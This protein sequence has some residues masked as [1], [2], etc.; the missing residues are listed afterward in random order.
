MSMVFFGWIRIRHIKHVGLSVAEQWI[1]DCRS[2]WPRRFDRLG[3]LLAQ[4]DE[5]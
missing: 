3:D 1:R 5:N 4:L 2:L